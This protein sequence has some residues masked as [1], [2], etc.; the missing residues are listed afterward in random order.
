ML[1]KTIRV[2]KEY[3]GFENERMKPLQA[4]DFAAF[5]GTRAAI[6]EPVSGKT[7][8]GPGDEQG[9]GHLMYKLEKMGIPRRLTERSARAYWI[10][11]SGLLILYQM[12]TPG[13]QTVDPPDSYID[14]FVD[15]F[16]IRDQVQ[17]VGIIDS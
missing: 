1:Y 11:A 2:L 14:K 13:G 15:V 12:E 6:I 9:H 3:N 7:L 17:R 10:P 5:S 16:G 8:E 4:W